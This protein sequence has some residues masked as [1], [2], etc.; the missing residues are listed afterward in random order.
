[1]NKSTFFWIFTTLTTL[2]SNLSFSEQEKPAANLEQHKITFL[3]PISWSSDVQCNLSVTIPPNFRS[4]IPMSQWD[5]ATMVEFI[6]EGESENTWSEII[7]ISKLIG[8]RISASQITQHLEKTLPTKSTNFKV[9]ESSA[10]KEPLYVRATLEVSYNNAG[11]HEILSCRY[12]SGPYDCAGIQYTI[13]PKA[14]QT[15]EQILDR[16]KAFFESNVQTI[17]CNALQ[18]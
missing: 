10:V 17:D 18:S 4:L 15:D 3:L 1:M 8:Q 12:Y 6:P 5:Q 11:N 13:R 16:I 14:G 7:T 2:T 9:I